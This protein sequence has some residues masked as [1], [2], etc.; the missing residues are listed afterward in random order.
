MPVLL[1]GTRGVTLI[2]LLVVLAIA[3]ILV[4]GLYRTFVG[5]QKT[6]TVQEQ[7]VDMQ[8]NARIAMNRM[9]QEIRQAGFGKVAMVTSVLQPNTPV[10]GALTI[11]VVANSTALKEISDVNR[12]KV[13]NNVFSS[14]M[15]SIGGIESHNMD[16]A[17]PPELDPKDNYYFITLK[18]GESILNYHP[19]NITPV[20]DIGVI[21]YRLENGTITRNG[22]VLADNIE[23]LQFR[24][25]TSSTDE[26]GTDA[27]ANPEQ[28]QR[29]RITVR[30]RTS[31]SDPAYGG[32]DGFRRREMTSYVMIRNPLT[33]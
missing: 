1:K 9:I 12:I 33:P 28:V 13:T 20:Y 27:P 11:A 4:A 6:Y 16:P 14:T 7:V 2:E 25:Y 29:V 3:T 26:V 19:I 24:Y 17:K 22:E 15:F 5:Q 23:S 31:L 21:T 32:G 30:A 10:L 18:P 8:Q